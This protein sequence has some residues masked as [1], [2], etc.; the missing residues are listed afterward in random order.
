MPAWAA[1]ALIADSLITDY[2]VAS[3]GTARKAAQRPRR[4]GLVPR[5]EK[6]ALQEI[7]LTSVPIAVLF[8]P[9]LPIMAL[10]P[11]VVSVNVNQRAK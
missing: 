9:S 6:A 5:R 4:I 2:F 3:I 10:A 8:L 7:D 11:S 1:S